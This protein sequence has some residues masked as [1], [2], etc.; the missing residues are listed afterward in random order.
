MEMT[1]SYQSIA[2]ES[3]YSAI[4]EYMTAIL[5]CRNVERKINYLINLA[6]LC[7]DYNQGVY[8]SKVYEKALEICL[9]NE[10]GIFPRF[11]NQALMA[12]RSIRSVEENPEKQHEEQIKAFYEQ[13]FPRFQ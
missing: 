9:E 5:K 2:Q 4:D 1:N 10:T 13:R 3:I 11:K 7:Y 8:A 6:S 12:A